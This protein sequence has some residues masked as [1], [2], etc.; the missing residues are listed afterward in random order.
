MFIILL[1]KPQFFFCCRSHSFVK[2]LTFRHFKLKILVKMIIFSTL[3]LKRLPN[4]FNFLTIFLVL[5]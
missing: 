3:K 1:H 2:N 5:H 4:I